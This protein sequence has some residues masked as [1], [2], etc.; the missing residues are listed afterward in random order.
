MKIKLIDVTTEEEYMELGTCELCFSYGEEEIPTFHFEKDDGTKFDVEAFYIEWGCPYSLY[1][2]NA[3]TFAGYLASLD[4][5]PD[6][7]KQINAKGYNE[8]DDY[9]WLSNLLRDYA[10]STF[11]KDPEYDPSW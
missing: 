3:I 6:F 4:F 10:E 8:W 11:C 7:D 1:V 2:D 9:A 5:D